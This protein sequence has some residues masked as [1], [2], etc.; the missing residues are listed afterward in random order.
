[1]DTLK[2]IE[3]IIQESARINPGLPLT[4]VG[5]T[6][7]WVNRDKVELSSLNEASAA[8]EKNYAWKW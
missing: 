4:G 7:P 6:G 1:M 2:R 5:T 3:K 8:Q